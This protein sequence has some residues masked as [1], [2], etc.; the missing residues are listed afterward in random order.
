MEESQEIIR[1]RRS[2]KPIKL[3]SNVS[4]SGDIEDCIEILS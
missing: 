4:G 1:D 3:E 2:G